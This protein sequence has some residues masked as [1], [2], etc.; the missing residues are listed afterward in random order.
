VTSSWVNG[1][2][3]VLLVIGGVLVLVLL[4]RV[5]ARPRN[6][7]AEITAA[8]LLPAEATTA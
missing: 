5:V 6:P 4:E 2:V 3:S 1:L 7:Q 8:S